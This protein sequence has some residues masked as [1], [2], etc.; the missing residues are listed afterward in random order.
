MDAANKKW[1]MNSFM[2]TCH[3]DPQT[4]VSQLKTLAAPDEMY[5][6]RDHI[7]RVAQ[8]PD[9]LYRELHIATKRGFA[10]LSAEGSNATAT[11]SKNKNKHEQELREE[12]TRLF[13]MSPRPSF[14]RTH[15]TYN[16]Q[17]IELCVPCLFLI[18]RAMR[19][20]PLFPLALKVW[21]C[22]SSIFCT[23]RNTVSLSTLFCVQ[24]RLTCSGRT[25]HVLTS[26]SW[27]RIY[28]AAW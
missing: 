2:I 26:A 16:L 1:E 11:Q 12:F 7:S 27:P 13:S 18:F 28:P 23:K 5:A 9:F 10:T 8:R 3:K 4:R 20:A 19:A 6:F 15:A 22:A 25:T 17:P 24:R 21:S 14:F